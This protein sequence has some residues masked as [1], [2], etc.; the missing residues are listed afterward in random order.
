MSLMADVEVDP[1]N[2]V[3]EKML[4]T[5]LVRTMYLLS[6]LGEMML[7]TVCAVS[8]EVTRI[9]K[10]RKYLID[11]NILPQGTCCY[12]FRGHKRKSL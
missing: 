10:F 11:E 2:E 3:L 4:A 12:R 5:E 8:N 1:W 9:V 7:Y 6:S